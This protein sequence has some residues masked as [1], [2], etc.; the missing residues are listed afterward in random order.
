M[1]GRR[2]KRKDNRNKGMMV[3][4]CLLEWKLKMER[5]EGECYYSHGPFRIH[6]FQRWVEN[7]N[8]KSGISTVRPKSKI[9]I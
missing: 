8:M 5:K 9:E 4:Y 7:S 1:F 3:F 6:L 2:E